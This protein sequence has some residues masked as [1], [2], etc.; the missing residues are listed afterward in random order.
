ML[1][2]RSPRSRAPTAAKAAPAKRVAS[3]KATFTSPSRRSRYAPA[4]SATVATSAAATAAIL[5][6]VVVLTRGLSRSQNHR[7]GGAGTTEA[8]RLARP[9]FGHRKVDCRCDLAVGRGR[10]QPPRPGGTD[11]AD[12]LGGGH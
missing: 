3:P 9:Y 6:R 1:L 12:H 7:S 8:V 11:P 4:A 10:R 2:G 5:C